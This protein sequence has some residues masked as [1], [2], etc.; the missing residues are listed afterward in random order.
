MTTAKRK[1]PKVDRHT[2]L[3][4]AS[5]MRG[6][7]TAHLNGIANPITKAELATALQPKIDEIKYDMGSFDYLLSDMAKNELISRTDREDGPPVYGPFTKANGKRSESGNAIDNRR[8]GQQ[9]RS[10][11]A[12]KA[13]GEELSTKEAKMLADYEAGKNVK[14]LDMG[15]TAKKKEGKATKHSKSGSELTITHPTAPQHPAFPPQPLPQFTK[16][17]LPGVGIQL[18][19]TGG[20]VMQIV[21]NTPEQFDFVLASL[22]KHNF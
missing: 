19:T 9:I 8:V 22:K 20:S 2:S 21:S 18:Y 16:G 12:R 5:F 3:V 11:K 7:I 10:L 6:Q 13:R 17:G 14:P 1:S 4:N 15:K